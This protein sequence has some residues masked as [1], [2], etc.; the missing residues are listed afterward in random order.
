M[1]KKTTLEEAVQG[2]FQFQKN[3]GYTTI[4]LEGMNCVYNRL[5]KLAKK[6]GDL[7]LS[8]ELTEAFLK[9]CLD[10]KN[11]CYSRVKH[12]A[13]RRCIRWITQF[14]ETGTT[15]IK[16]YSKPITLDIT[17][18]FK[19]SL[20]IYDISEKSS[21]L[22][23]SSLVKNRRPIRYLLEYMTKL[24]YNQLSDIKHG[25][26]INAIQEMLEKHYSPSSLITAICGM[27]RFYRMFDELHPFCLE[28]PAR[29]PR[30][31]D[32]IDTYTEEEQDKI[33]AYLISNQCSSRDIAICLLS[34]E[35]GIRSV[36]ICNL[37]LENIDWKHDMIHIVQSKTQRALNLPLRSSYGN[38]IMNYVLNERPKSDLPYVFLSANMPYSK[39][40]V[41]WHIV[42]NSIESAG[43]TTTNRLTGTR[44]FRHNVASTMVKRGIPL[45]VI[46][47]ELGH[48]SMDSTMVYI[49]TNQQK[50]STLTLPLPKGGFIK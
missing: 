13:H 17:E 1:N 50:L 22:S 37:K 42:K 30:K 32:I 14:I 23:E 7:Y 34:F 41:T 8:D 21:G 27:R 5:L 28:I 24:G 18:E 19:E 46:A 6:R 39:L 48:K 33:Y 15:F 31:R 45:P 36:D 2:A 20:K 43:V 47:E 12:N 49:S 10:S 40:N 35:T 4:T 3:A 26:T 38:A 9:D 11:H 16:R 29:I 25:D 44:M